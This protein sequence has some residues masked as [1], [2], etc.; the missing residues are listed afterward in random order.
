MKNFETFV[1][2][3]IKKWRTD[4]D[5]ILESKGLSGL[6]NR[7]YG[8]L[9]ED[10]IYR[11]IQ[12]LQPNYAPFFSNGSQSPADILAVGRRNGYWHIMLIQTKS[13]DNIKDIY[14]LN[15]EDIKAFGAFAKF[16]KSEIINSG[17]LDDY[18]TKPIIIST[19]YTSVLRRNLNT[20]ITHTLIEAKAFKKKFKLN[21][22]DLDIEAVKKAI[23]QT[24]KL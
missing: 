22:S 3:V 1:D 24:H 20:R 8:D 23:D 10:Y 14:Q 19:G 7:E 11:K 16:V 2:Y 12:K 13:S 15:T 6:T 21:A 5:I 18:K 4:K 9:A 17:I